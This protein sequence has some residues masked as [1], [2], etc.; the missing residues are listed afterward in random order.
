QYGLANAMFSTQG[1]GS[2]TAHQD[3]IRGGSEIDSTESFIDDPTSSS[4]WGC[5]SPAGTK[6]NLITTSLAYE[7][8]KGP[9]PCTKDFSSYGSYDYSTLADLLDAAGISWKY[10]TPVFKKGTSS[11]LWNG[12]D[13]IWKVRNGPEWTTNISSPETNIFSDL[14]SGTLPSMSWVIPDAC[15]SDHPGYTCDTGPSWVTSVVNAVGQS[16]YWNSTAIIVVWDDWGGFYD[17]VSPDPLDDQGGPGFR[18]PMLAISPYV[19]A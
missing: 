10:Y 2:F 5:D 15:N 14:T 11:A 18:V 13:V 6:T 16:S 9:F 8:N 4:A 7:A 1:S 17:P 19:P 3:L 12:F